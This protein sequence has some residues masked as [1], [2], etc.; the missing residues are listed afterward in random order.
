MRV[1]DDEEALGNH[2]KDCI[3][4]W[5]QKGQGPVVSSKFHK[6]SKILPMFIKNK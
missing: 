5:L 1:Y 3:L 2:N 6:I 4:Q